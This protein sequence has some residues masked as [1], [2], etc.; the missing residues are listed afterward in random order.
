MELPRS[1]AVGKQRLG[2]RSPKA[3]R[4]PICGFTTFTA[5]QVGLMTAQETPS[6][7]FGADGYPEAGLKWRFHWG[8]TPIEVESPST[9]TPKLP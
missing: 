6:G 2:Q 7:I 1:G 9:P 5:S 3:L 4:T 8:K